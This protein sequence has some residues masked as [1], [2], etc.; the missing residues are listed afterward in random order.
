MPGPLPKD[1]RIRQRRHKKSTRA[2]LPAEANPLER[3]PNMPAHPF[4]AEWHV[5]ARRFWDDTWASPV[6]AEFLRVDAHGI[7]RLLVL[8]DDFWKN[9]TVA[10]SREI[11]LMGQCYG[12]SPIDRRRLEY[13]VASTEEAIAKHHEARVK[14]AT[15]VDGGSDPRSFLADD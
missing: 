4:G 14:R 1:P 3:K 9:P 6:A 8:V 7:F 15:V 11:R 13:S 5:M 2:T 10:L 12:L